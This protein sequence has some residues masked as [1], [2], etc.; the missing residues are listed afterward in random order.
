M[1][2]LLEKAQWLALPALALVIACAAMM[3]EVSSAHAQ[4][5]QIDVNCVVLKSSNVRSGPGTNFKV[6]SGLKAGATVTVDDAT[7][8]GSWLHHKAGWTAE[9]LLDCAGEEVA[10][11]AEVSTGTMTNTT[12]SS[13]W[14]IQWLA[15]ATTQMKGQGENPWPGF[16]ALAP[17][18]WPEFPNVDN[19]GANF[20]AKDGLEFGE[21]ESQFCGVDDDG[22]SLVV[23]PRSYALV[24]GSWQLEGLGQCKGSE[25]FGCALLIANV[26]E[27]SAEFHGT[28]DN[29]YIVQG[30]YWNGDRLPVAVVAVLSHATNN[31]TNQVSK[32][33]P[34]GIT[35][36]GGNCSVVD[37]CKGVNN[38]FKITSGNELLISGETNWGEVQTTQPKQPKLDALKGTK[39]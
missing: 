4:S 29:V 34:E 36:A 3:F 26:G 10:E 19:S 16:T 32:L 31:M 17:L 8:D 23:P 38:Q 5:A 28:L 33:N 11:N 22:C 39:A 20:S 18:N 13:E 6:V 27:V 21:D 37:G 30:R 12:M 25:T 2:K 14:A 15:G 7:A 1:S 9:F 35:N 24:T